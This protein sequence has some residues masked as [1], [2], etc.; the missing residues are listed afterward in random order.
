[1]SESAQ[2]PFTKRDYV[3]VVATGV[4]MLCWLRL[5]GFPL[6]DWDTIRYL[7]L[8]TEPWK[9]PETVPVVQYLWFSPAMKLLGIWALP[10]VANLLLLYTMANASKII[11]GRVSIV[12]MLA[13]LFLS[14]MHLWVN[15]VLVDAY[16]PIGVVAIFC[17]AQGRHLPTM[18]AV[19]I[20]CCFAHSAN[21]VV[22]PPLAFLA[23]LYQRNWRAMTGFVAGL[24]L[25]TLGIASIVKYKY[26]HFTPLSLYGAGNL[27][28]RVMSDFPETIQEYAALH[29]ES[30]IRKHEALL[31][32]KATSP[33][34]RKDLL[35][36]I[37]GWFP[38]APYRWPYLQAQAQINL[39]FRG[40]FKMA[41]WVP[42]GFSKEEQRDYVRYVARTRPMRFYTIMLENLALFTI[43]AGTDGPTD[44]PYQCVHA[45]ISDPVKQLIQ[46]FVPQSEA[47]FANSLQ[48][49]SKNNETLRRWLFP[50]M[51]FAVSF[52]ISAVGGILV[53]AWEFWKRPMQISARA[54]FC[55]IAMLAWLAEA[56][57]MA[58]ISSMHPR[59]YT[60]L[61]FVTV[62]PFVLAVADAGVGW[63]KPR[64]VASSVG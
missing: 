10:L 16:F 39:T 56:F 5:L 23:M 29:P 60:L 11:L 19:A 37:P 3:A 7:E 31:T 4:A 57:V 48:M 25:A 38:L 17:A 58:N 9:T 47:A 1:M 2:A 14:G 30:A 18:L 55:V 6:L 42:Q 49:K 35:A 8:V 34:K 33:A 59:Y 44:W 64:G 24:L 51:L 52:L 22:L 63:R 54:Q 12:V 53:A 50:G 28:A 15:F 45:K 20:Y 43:A 32:E 13:S 27:V 62:Y 26:D 41:Q 40:A 61:Y 21:F 46:P 36:R